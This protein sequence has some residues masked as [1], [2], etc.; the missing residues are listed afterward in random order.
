MSQEN[1]EVV[2]RRFDAFNRLGQPGDLVRPELDLARL[3]LAHLD[4]ATSGM[5]RH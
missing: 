4:W 1:V 2:P 3:G 5:A